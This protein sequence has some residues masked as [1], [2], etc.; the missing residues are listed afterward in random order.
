MSFGL[1]I[2]VIDDG[3]EHASVRG[4]YGRIK[5]K[6]DVLVFVRRYFDFFWLDVERELLDGVGSLLFGFQLN[7]AGY[8]IVVLNLYFLDQVFRRIFG[9]DKCTEVEDSLVDVKHVGLDHSLDGAGLMLVLHHQLLLK[10]PLE[11]VS[12]DARNA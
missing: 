1:L 6:F 8:F 2:A 12:V 4:H 3:R 11:V 9:G 7:C 10:Y 5:D